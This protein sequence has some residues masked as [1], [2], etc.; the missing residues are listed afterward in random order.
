MPQDYEAPA[1][2]AIGDEDEVKPTSIVAV[3][4]AVVAVGIAVVLAGVLLVEFW[5]AGGEPAC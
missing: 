4:A 5:I 3:A 2:N 1:I